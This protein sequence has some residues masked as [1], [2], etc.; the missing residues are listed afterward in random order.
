METPVKSQPD[1]LTSL[2][3]DMF[4]IVRPTTQHQIIIHTDVEIATIEPTFVIRNNHNL[5]KTK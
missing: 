2:L 1:K 3:N 5:D 4:R